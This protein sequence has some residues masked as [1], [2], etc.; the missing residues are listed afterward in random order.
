MKEKSRGK[1]KE[2]EDLT[3]PFGRL[4]RGGHQNEGKDGVSARSKDKKRTRKKIN[5]LVTSMVP[6]TGE[7]R[8]RKKGVHNA[9][10]C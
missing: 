2:G 4:K 5:D 8:A 6:T 9:E 10:L 7:R 1:G 3:P